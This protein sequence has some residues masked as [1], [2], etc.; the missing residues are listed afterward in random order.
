MAPGQQVFCNR[1]V[2]FDRIEVLGF[3]YDYTLA[4]YGVELQDL[5]Y[6]KVCDPTRSSGSGQ[7]RVGVGA[8]VRVWL[9]FRTCSSASPA[10]TSPNPSPNEPWP[11]P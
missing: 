6:S 9:S 10:P 1:E 5:I 8:R 7:G 2:R 11:A 3:D 4:S